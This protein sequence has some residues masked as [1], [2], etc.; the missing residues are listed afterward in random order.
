ME[1]KTKQC[2]QCKARRPITD[3]Q[4]PRHKICI[5]CVVERRNAAIWFSNPKNSPVVPHVDASSADY[6]RWYQRQ[7]YRANK[8]QTATTPYEL[9][10]GKLCRRCQKWKDLSEFGSWRVRICLACDGPTLEDLVRNPPS[11]RE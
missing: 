8:M 6:N 10:K 2:R 9:P 3:Y 4:T 5:P 1:Q 7:R 11:L